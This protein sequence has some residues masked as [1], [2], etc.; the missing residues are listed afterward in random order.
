[1]IRLDERG[2]PLSLSFCVRSTYG[3]P[4]TL[5]SSQ[6]LCELRKSSGF[7]GLDAGSNALMGIINNLA[8][9]LLGEHRVFGS[10]LISYR[11]AQW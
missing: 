7:S 2:I 5:A 1:M 3:R 6:A 8:K 11:T 10:F 4:N 9:L